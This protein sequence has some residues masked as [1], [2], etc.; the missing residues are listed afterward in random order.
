L[1]FRRLLRE[2][3]IVCD[4]PDVTFFQQRS[5]VMAACSGLANVINYG[6]NLIGVGGCAYVRSS[7]VRNIYPF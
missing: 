4:K 7:E 6:Y 2:L 5:S 1:D 3:M